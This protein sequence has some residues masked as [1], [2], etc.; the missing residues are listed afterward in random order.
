MNEYEK[1]LDEL[2]L[3]LKKSTRPQR[4]FVVSLM[5]IIEHFASLKL[6]RVENVYDADHALGVATRMILAKYPSG[7]IHSYKWIE[8]EGFLVNSDTQANTL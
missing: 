2:R 8:V 4:C 6:V 1:M 5:I 3:G 7:S